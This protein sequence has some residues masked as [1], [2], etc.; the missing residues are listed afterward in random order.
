MVAIG[1]GRA[2]QTQFNWIV[3]GVAAAVNIGLNVV[4][5]PPY[6]MIGAAIATLVAYLDA[7]RRHGAEL[8]AASTR[9]PTS[10]A[11]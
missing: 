2:R 6:G 1:I 5:I 9:S 3:S 7:L 8:A 10:G 11:A 4:L